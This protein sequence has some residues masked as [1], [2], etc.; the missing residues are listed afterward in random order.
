MLSARLFSSTSQSTPSSISSPE[1][2]IVLVE[3][4]TTN[5]Y[6]AK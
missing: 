6:D 5:P 3:A 2:V 4:I 1:P